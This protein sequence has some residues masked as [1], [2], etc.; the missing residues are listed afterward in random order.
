M[1]NG[2]PAAPAEPGGL[3]K[4]VVA[5][6]Q[7]PEPPA[8]VRAFQMALAVLCIAGAFAVAIILVTQGPPAPKPPEES[9]NA[10][11]STKT[12]SAAP[13]QS[14]LI[15]YAATEDESSSE[16]EGGEESEEGAGEPEGSIPDSLSNLNEQ[17]PWA[18]AIVALLVGAFIATGKS[19]NFSGTKQ[20]SPG[21]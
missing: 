7:D 20:G 17:A 4:A 11:G 16:E 10:S 1:T 18:F 2:E 9:N 21:A 19:L 5:A 6:N 12:T 8:W 13:R 3:A 14:A 15:T